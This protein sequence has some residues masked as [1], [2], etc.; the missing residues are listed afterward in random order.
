MEYMTDARVKDPH[1][2][3]IM[4]TENID[5]QNYVF[6][7]NAGTQNWQYAE[8]EVGSIWGAGTVDRSTTPPTMNPQLGGGGGSGGGGSGG[9][10]ATGEDQLRINNSKGKGSGTDYQYCRPS[11]NHPQSVNVAYVGQNVAQ[12]RDSVS[13]FVFA[14]LMAS[15]DDNL[16]T[17]G[18]NTLMDAALRQY[19]ITEADIGP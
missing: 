16:K 5:A 18:M 6:S 8:I 14:K 15:D 12:L 4:L 9:G 7:T 19:P 1:A 17:V 3:T 11:S 13:Y 10:G 2:M